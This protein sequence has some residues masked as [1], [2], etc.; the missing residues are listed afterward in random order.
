M[1]QPKGNSLESLRVGTNSY[2]VLDSSQVNVEQVKDT[3]LVVR[4]CRVKFLILAKCFELLFGIFYYCSL[5]FILF[6][7][8]SKAE[9]QFFNARGLI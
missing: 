5:L 4:F 8:K 2:A 1:W 3:D 6:I 9:M 7:N